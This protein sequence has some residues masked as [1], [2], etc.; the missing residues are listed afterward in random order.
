[1]L[2]ICYDRK[3]KK[4]KVIGSTAELEKNSVKWERWTNDAMNTNMTQ[5]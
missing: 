2:P 3:H 5:L 1:M 4:G